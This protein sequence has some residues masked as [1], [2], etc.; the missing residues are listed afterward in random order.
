M[1]STSMTGSFLHVLCHSIVKD[2]LFLCAGAIIYKTHKTNVTELTGIGKEMPV[3]MWCFTLCS[4]ALVGIPPMC[5]FM[6]K[7]YLALGS[8]SSGI[9]VISWLGPV[10]LLISALLTA[11]YLLPVSIRGFFPGEGFDYA[12]LEKK[13]PTAWMLIPLVILAF[14]AAFTFFPQPFMALIERVTAPLL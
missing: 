8:L 14:L 13:E 7:W 5:G 1:N 2:G 6:S 10:I 11:A 3:V 9:P 4:L 12:A